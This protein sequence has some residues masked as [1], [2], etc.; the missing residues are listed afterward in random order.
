MRK[1]TS[2]EISRYSR[3]ELKEFIA[4]HKLEIEKKWLGPDTDIEDLRDLVIAAYTEG[5][6]DEGGWF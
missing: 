3:A 2:V 6:E 1:K 4:Y 5:D